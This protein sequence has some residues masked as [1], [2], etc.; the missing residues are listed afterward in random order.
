MQWRPPRSAQ[1]LNLPLDYDKEQT[2]PLLGGLLSRPV[3]MHGALCRLLKNASIPLGP[4]TLV[5]AHSTTT[6]TNRE[7][8]KLVGERIFYALQVRIWTI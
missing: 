3:K 6:L 5:C 8:Y 7:L 2:L 1:T 4:G